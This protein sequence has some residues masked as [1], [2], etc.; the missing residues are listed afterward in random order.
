M[1]KPCPPQGI[2]GCPDLQPRMSLHPPPRR[3]CPRGDLARASLPAHSAG[4]ASVP[5]LPPAS[6]AVPPLPGLLLCLGSHCLH[7]EVCFQ[8]LDDKKVSSSLTLL[9]CL[10]QKHSY[11]KPQGGSQLC[12]EAM[13]VWR[14]ENYYRSALKHASLPLCFLIS[15]AIVLS[16]F[17]GHFE[18]ERLDD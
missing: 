12:G 5:Q 7:G 14:W 10:G 17:F 8:C 1:N 2:G 15:L 4:P 6:E 16:D 9:E 18:V 3:T 13:R 11:L